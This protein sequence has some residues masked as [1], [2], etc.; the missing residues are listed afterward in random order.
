L[1]ERGTL[2]GDEVKEVFRESVDAQMQKE[3][4]ELEVTSL[5]SRS[6]RQPPVPRAIPAQWSWGD[7]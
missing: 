3:G 5:K 7:P 6:L 2:I 4:K 1:I